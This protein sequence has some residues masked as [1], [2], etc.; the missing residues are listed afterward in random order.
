MASEPDV[1]VSN[2]PSKPLMIWDGDCHFCRR[3][4]ERWREMTAGRVDYEPFQTCAPRFPEIPRIEFEKAVQ[5]IE[6]DGRVFRA[7]E[8]AYSFIA[9]HRE[10]ASK[11]TRLLWG[12]D[13]RC[14]TYFTARRIFLRALGV[15]Y[16]IAFV[17]LWLQVDGLIGADGIS[18]VHEFL[19][20]AKEQLGTGAFFV[21]PTLCWL[22][23]S[24]LFL[25]FLC[26]G[27]ALVSVALIAGLVPV[28]SL[29]A[30]LVFYLSLTIAGQ[31][32]LSFQW[33]ILLLETGFLA[34]FFAPLSWRINSRQEAPLSRVGLFLLKLLLFKLMFM[35]GVVKLTSGDGSWWKLTA[36]DYHYWTQPLPTVL[37]WWAAQ[38][39]EWLKHFCTFA[40]LLVESAVPFLIWT[41]RRLRFLAFVLLVSGQIMIALTGNYCFFNLLTIALCVLLLDDAQISRRA[42]VHEEILGAPGG[43]ALPM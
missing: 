6:T 36:L 9:R 31:T 13:V 7:A 39:S 32:F 33:D 19:P 16:L 30:L 41:P 35:S 28:F 14:P 3:W 12:K 17:S 27:G 2:P 26:G 38:T 22:N 40:I 1:R 21:L 15:I 34:I 18:P 37:G 10:F 42:G 11:V 43:R 8:A 23:S 24:N 5:F 29:I 25:H 4:I 20:A